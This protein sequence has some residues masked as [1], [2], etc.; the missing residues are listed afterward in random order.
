[1]NETELQDLARR[2]GEVIIRGL[3]TRSTWALRTALDAAE[4]EGVA[5][6]CV[7]KIPAKSKEFVDV[8]FTIG[9]VDLISRWDVT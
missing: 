4:T 8:T 2:V 7:M 1:M 3:G 6:M 9:R 5:G